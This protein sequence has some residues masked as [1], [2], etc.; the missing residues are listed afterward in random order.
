MKRIF[1]LLLVLT[2]PI[3]T[4]GQLSKKF[5]W[6]FSGLSLA[7]Y[8]ANDQMIQNGPN[9]LPYLLASDGAYLGGTALAI[10][11]PPMSW[12][13]SKFNQRAN[14]KFGKEI[15]ISSIVFSLA[16]AGWADAIIWS[17]G[18]SVNTDWYYPS[19]LL[20]ITLPTASMV[21][22]SPISKSEATIATTAGML[23]GSVAWDIV[24]SKA[25]YGDPFYRVPN[26]YGGWAPKDYK[27][28]AVARIG[29]AAIILLSGEIFE[30]KNFIDFQIYASNNKI[31]LAVT[32]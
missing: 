25:R 23:I 18:H 30:N 2:I 9:S 5:F 7:R 6:V 15:Y 14:R 12:A 27:K 3:A 32:F 16:N 24:F 11:A 26:W 1:F 10:S 20:A 28:F 29:A 4:F 8:W 19:S 13:F 31:F 21:Y 22:W 17:P